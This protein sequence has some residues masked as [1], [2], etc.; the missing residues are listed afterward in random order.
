LRFAGN[1]TV[2]IE[3]TRQASFST[4]FYG[5]IRA[6]RLST[7]CRYTQSFTPPTP[8]EMKN[9]DVTEVLLDFSRPKASVIRD[10]SGNGHH[11]TIT[12]AEWVAIDSG[13]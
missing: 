1:Q 2:E 4:G 11:G 13:Q 7:V 5:Q 9:D 3:G 10:L 12:G 6:F 8:A